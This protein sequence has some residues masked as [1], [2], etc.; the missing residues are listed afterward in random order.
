MPTKSRAAKPAAETPHATHRFITDRAS[1]AV[2]GWV[3]DHASFRQWFYQ[4]DFPEEGRVSF[5]NGE[6]IFDMS[7]EQIYSHLRMKMVISRVLDSLATRR[8]MGV[9][10]P[11]G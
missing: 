3:V 11:D 1:I 7:Q 2:P 8:K 5:L 4:P 6:V 9:F 10:Y